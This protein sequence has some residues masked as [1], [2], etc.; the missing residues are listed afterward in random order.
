VAP[1]CHTNFWKEVYVLKKAAIALL[2]TLILVA[3]YGTDTLASHNLTIGEC[4]GK[5]QKNAI[6]QGTSEEDTIGFAIGYEY[7]QECGVF[8]YGLGTEFQLNAFF[9][10]NHWGRYYKKNYE[11]EELFSF[12]P[13]YSVV[14]LYLAEGEILTPYLT[15]RLGYNWQYGNDKYISDVDSRLGGGLYYALGLGFK[16]NEYKFSFAFLYIKNEG[17]YELS[18]VSSDVTFSRLDVI[19]SIE[20]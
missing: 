12:I 20:F 16:H 1:I 6:G 17:T 11:W 9:D 8:E 2:L 18:G 15:G 14:K 3:L 10:W 4:L 7:L 13:I 19:F 5:W